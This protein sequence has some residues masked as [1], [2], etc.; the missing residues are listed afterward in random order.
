M[1]FTDLRLYGA[2]KM[3]WLAA[4]LPAEGEDREP[5]IG[6]LMRSDVPRCRPGERLGDLGSRWREWPWCAVVDDDGVLLGR[7]RRSELDEHPDWPA[8]EAAEPGPSTYR[9]SVPAG[10][11]RGVMEKGGHRHLYVSDGEGRLLGIVTR[12]DLDRAAV[13]DPTAA[14]PE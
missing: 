5:T 6:E 11:L 10:E 9:P 4:G 7:V 13:P 12:D 2:G 1:G 3:D 14:S 8:F